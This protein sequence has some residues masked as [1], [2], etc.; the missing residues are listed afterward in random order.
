[1][2]RTVGCIRVSKAESQRIK[3]VGE[4]KA[5]QDRGYKLRGLKAE[6]TSF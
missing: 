6:K 5:A 2:E 4:M 3:G 1:M